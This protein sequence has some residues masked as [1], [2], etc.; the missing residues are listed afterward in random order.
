MGAM[1]LGHRHCPPKGQLGTMATGLEGYNFLRSEATSRELANVSS[2]LF[3]NQRPHP[4]NE[5][6]QS[7]RGEAMRADPLAFGVSVQYA[8]SGNDFEEGQPKYVSSPPASIAS[9]CVAFWV[10]WYSYQYIYLQSRL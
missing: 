6:A 3:W 8:S 10:V 4:T 5:M 9:G 7:P 2:H 1:R